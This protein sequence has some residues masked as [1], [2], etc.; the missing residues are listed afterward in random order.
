VAI[1]APVLYI[2]PKGVTTRYGDEK[3]RGN[4]II[5]SPDEKRLYVT[6]G[7]TLIAF[8]VQANGALTNQ[9]EFAAYENGP[10]DGLA[11]DAAGRVY[12]SGGGAGVRVIDSDGKY[13]GMIPTP[14]NTTTLAFGGPDKKMLYAI[15]ARTDGG[16]RL[17]E[18]IGIKMI[19]QG[20]R[21]RPK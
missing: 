13:L 18:L 17:V 3:L 5:L 10:G 7:N 12:V 6:T 14:A 9:R 4:G 20:Y 2:D 1:G 21:G 15:Q 8:D 19:A 16:R 11:V